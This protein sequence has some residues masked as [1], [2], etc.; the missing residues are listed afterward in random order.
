MKKVLLGLIILITLIVGFINYFTLGKPAL[1]IHAFG[2]AS[3]HHTRMVRLDSIGWIKYD[4]ID[5]IR[6]IYHDLGEPL[7]KNGYMLVV[8]GRFEFSGGYSDG[9]TKPVAEQHEGTQFVLRGKSGTILVFG[10]RQ[11]PDYKILSTI[12][13]IRKLW[14]P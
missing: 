11:Q 1:F 13:P 14:L 9:K 6:S 4:D 10:Q 12:G 5:K 2:F 3:A 7:D 8:G